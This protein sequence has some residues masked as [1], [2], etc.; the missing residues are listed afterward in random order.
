[1]VLASI[2]GWQH[3]VCTCCG[4]K[5][6]KEQNARNRLEKSSTMQNLEG[7][8]ERVNDGSCTSSV[9]ISSV[10]TRHSCPGLWN[11]GLVSPQHLITWR[12]IVSFSLACL[13]YQYTLFAESHLKPY[14]LTGNS[15]LFLRIFTSEQCELTEN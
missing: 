3:N 8:R 12:E 7:N 5:L 6:G 14:L 1:M 15:V 11:L 10:W 4:R 9:S 13:K 2:P